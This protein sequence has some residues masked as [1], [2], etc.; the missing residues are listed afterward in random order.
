MSKLA[1]TILLAFTFLFLSQNTVKAEIT[2]TITPVPA[3]YTPRPFSPTNGFDEATFKADISFQ[4]LK[5][6]TVYYY[7]ESV[8]PNY[9]YT[10][11]HPFKEVGPSDSS[12]NLNIPPS[13][14]DGQ[15]GLTNEGCD[16]GSYFYG[17]NTYGVTLFD[18]NP[19]EDPLHKKSPVATAKFYVERYYP[20]AEP[21]ADNLTPAITIT[22]SGTRR[23]HNETTRNNYEIWVKHSSD[24]NIYSEHACINVRSG[25]PG[26]LQ[27]DL[28][29][30]TGSYT[31]GNYTIEVWEQTKE[32]SGNQCSSKGGFLYY[33]AT[34]RIKNDGTIDNFSGF[35]KDPKGNDTSGTAGE[36]H[37]KPEPGSGEIVCETAIG[38]I[39]ANPTAFVGKILAIATGLAGGIALIFMVI[40]SIK[41]L[42]SSGDQQKLNAG[43]DQ[44][45]A[46][47]AGL[48]FL[49]FSVLILRFFG[50]ILQIPFV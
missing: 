37:C 34:F 47:I 2:S 39:P 22:V 4:G 43:K 10:A 14:A 29:R 18:E 31:P 8:D 32:A 36:N 25:T 17:G 42:T 48:L 6:N 24:E 12:G 20:L 16:D 35:K 49:I 30:S 9:C 46:A 26:S 28:N 1:L 13:C 3:N 41:V 38:T 50:L 7:C 33:N 23:P 45:V 21:T 27:F 5:P 19:D 40:G 44:I 15:E 11:G